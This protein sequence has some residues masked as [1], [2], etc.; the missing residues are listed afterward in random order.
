MI[1]K[2]YK[3][4]IELFEKYDKLTGKIRIEKVIEM[5]LSKRFYTDSQRTKEAEEFILNKNN[6]LKDDG[7]IRLPDFI[8]YCSLIVHPL[9]KDTAFKRILYIHF[10]VGNYY[11]LNPQLRDD[12]N[13]DDDQSIHFGVNVDLQSMY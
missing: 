12:F 11:N 5:Q 10:K 4:I 6:L 3:Q 7:F 13:F 9:I 8:K 1:H 2:S